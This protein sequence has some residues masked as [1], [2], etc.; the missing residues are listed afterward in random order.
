MQ[1]IKYRPGAVLASGHRGDRLVAAATAL[2]ALALGT[3]AVRK[4]LSRISR[5]RSAPTRA[6]TAQDRAG[7]VMPVGDVVVETMRVTVE[8]VEQRISRSPLR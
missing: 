1:P 4:A 3:V 8:I 2:G 5:A 6:T 7:D